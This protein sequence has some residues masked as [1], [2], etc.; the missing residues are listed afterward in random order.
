VIATVTCLLAL[1]YWSQ[2]DLLTPRY[3]E[4]LFCWFTRKTAI[5]LQRFFDL[6]MHQVWRAWCCCVQLLVIV[7]D[8]TIYAEPQFLPESF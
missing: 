2:P 7:I 8:H 1:A 6:A 4:L 5:A 3:M